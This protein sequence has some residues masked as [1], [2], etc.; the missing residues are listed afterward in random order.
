MKIVRQNTGIYM[1]KIFIC[2]P[3][4]D[5]WEPLEVA[6]ETVVDPLFVRRETL[7]ICKV[8]LVLDDTLYNC[9]LYSVHKDY[10]SRIMAS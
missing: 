10:Q 8:P 7:G 5:E 3:G 1:T 9:I 2:A 4:K 6:K